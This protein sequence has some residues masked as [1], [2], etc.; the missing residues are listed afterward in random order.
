M[1]NVNMLDIFQTKPMKPLIDSEE[2]L[3]IYKNEN[4]F[5]AAVC[6][7]KNAEGEFKI[8][9]LEKA[10]FIDLNQDLANIGKDF[11]IGGRHPLPELQDF[12]RTL[13]K[14]GISNDTHVVIYDDHYGAYAARFWWMLKAIG[15]ESVQVLNGGMQE[16]T[17]FGFPLT[18]QIHKP[19]LIA[20]YKINSWL[21]PISTIDEVETANKNQK[22]RIIDVRDPERYQGENEPIDLIAGHIPNAINI[23]YKSNLNERGVFLTSEE[24]KKLYFPFVENYASENIIIHCGSGVTACH[25]ILAMNSAGFEFPKLYV[26]SW[27][28]WSRNNKE[29][30]GLKSNKKRD[31]CN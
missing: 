19:E 9:H 7:S 29:I 1:Y 30:V 2:L 18:N 22:F 5:I 16:A 17:R 13:S 6:N 21:L 10:V 23:P 8:Q 14:F 28:E 11:S 24:L 27:S 15:H 25:T 20:P 3:K 26:G 31:D 4:V 12:V